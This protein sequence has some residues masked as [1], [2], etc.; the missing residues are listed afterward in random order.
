MALENR[1]YENNKAAISEIITMRDELQDKRDGRTSLVK[2]LVRISAV[3]LGSGTFYFDWEN[4]RTTNPIYTLL[5]VIGYVTTSYFAGSALVCGVYNHYNRKIVDLN[6]DLDSLR[7]S[8][9]WPE[10]TMEAREKIID[11][12]KKEIV[13]KI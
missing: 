7:G 1:F 6:R 10:V 2:N 11:K 4:I 13:I 12:Y 3:T 9:R 8:W 5:A